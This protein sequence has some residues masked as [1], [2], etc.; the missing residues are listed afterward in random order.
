M[1]R[2]IITITLV[3]MLAYG[4]VNAAESKNF[5]SDGNIM[6]GEQWNAVSI[7]DTPPAH[8]TVNMSGGDVLSMYTYD[9][10]TLNMTDG[11]IDNL[12]SFEYSTVNVSGGFL[13]YGSMS[14]REQ[15]VINFSGTAE[16]LN[17]D[18]LNSARI[19]VSGGIISSLDAFND[20]ILNIYGG[21][22][23]DVWAQDN[24]IVNI[25]GHHDL[26]KISSGGI[27]GYGFV[28]GY[29]NDLSWF[30]FDL[31]GSETYSH[32]NLIPEPA[33]ILLLVAGG[34]FLRKKE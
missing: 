2:A 21:D 5:Y 24:T 13:G 31:R 10:S 11:S 14:A 9:A 29:Y 23:T 20:G 6:P 26:M 33:T 30:R 7:F 27:Y 16:A 3:M 1:K 18:A 19:N 8:T 4:S 25:F 12:F 32:I 15:S 17:V 34:I 22:I 28:Q